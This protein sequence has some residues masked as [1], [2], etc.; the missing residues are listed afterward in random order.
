MPVSLRTPETEKRYREHLKTLPEDYCV[1]CDEDKMSFEN[2]KASYKYWF[3][4]KNEF[5]YDAKHETSDML[6]CK[7]HVQH[8][9]ELT[10]DEML[11]VFSLLDE[12]KRKNLY[13][14]Q[15][16]NSDK[17]Q[18]MPLHIHWHLLNFKKS[19]GRTKK[20]ENTRR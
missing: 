2:R 5:P 15:V 9:R 3:I 11:E 8:L 4:V 6:V 14:Q 1:F 16:M 17:R 19:N 12:I 10:V 7:R 20:N 13:H 18:S